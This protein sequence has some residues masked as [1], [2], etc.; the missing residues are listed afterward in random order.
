MELTRLAGP[1]S[2]PEATD[3]LASRH[4]MIASNNQ[5]MRCKNWGRTVAA[6]HAPSGPQSELIAVA[7]LLALA[8]RR[9]D[10]NLFVVLLERRK[11]LTRLG[12]L[13]LLHTFAHIPVHKGALG[14]HQV[15]LMV[16][17]REDLGDGGGVADHAASAHHLGQVAAWDHG[18]RLVVDAALEA[19]GAPINKLNSP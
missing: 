2:S 7:L 6:Q 19:G 9:L 13:A 3:C 8:L 16:D 5:Q 12:E 10:A 17:A 4:R 11:I 18:G 14:V 1:I 15:E